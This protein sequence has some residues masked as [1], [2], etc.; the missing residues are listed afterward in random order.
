MKKNYLFSALAASLMLFASCSQEEII[1]TA[2]EPTGGE[3]VTISAALPQDAATRA[4][5][6]VEN[7]KARCILQ[8]VNASGTAIEGERY[9]KEVTGDN[10]TFEF[11]APDQTYQ[12]VLWADYIQ[13]VAET[14]EKDYFYTTSAL[15]S[16]TLGNL[17]KNVMFGTEAA[18]AFCGVIENPAD[19]VNITL[20]RPLA[21][22]NIGSNTPANYEKYTHVS[23]GK[24]NVPNNYNILT[25]Q[26]NVNTTQEIRLDK[27]AMIDAEAGQW[28]YFFVF[29]PVD[30][31]EYTLSIPVTIN[32]EAGS[33]E[34]KSATV[35]VI[36][37]DDNKE[38]NINFTPEGGSGEEPEPE[39]SDDMTINVGFDNE[40]EKPA[41]E[42]GAYVNAAGKLVEDAAEAVAI[43]FDMATD[44]DIANYNG[45]F[46]GKTIK[47]WAVAL[48]DATQQKW[49]DGVDA[50][51]VIDGVENPGSTTAAEACIKG[52]ANT[53]AIQ[54]NGTTA[55]PGA[56]F[57]ALEACVDWAT[58]ISETN[59]SG[60]YMPAIG[61]VKRL[62]DAIASAEGTNALSTLEFT[63]VILSSSLYTNSNGTFSTGIQFTTTVENAGVIRNQNIN[64]SYGA[65]PIVTIFE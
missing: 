62:Y 12:C 61:Q 55:N 36:P 38:S 47:A 54:A 46:P 18:D 37:V 24:M 53:Q 34:D 41:I 4:M 49:I 5:A 10:V 19:G 27:T 39:P 3:L 30:R 50:I 17:N 43:V 9:V 23:V 29:A 1:S 16:V 48:G 26:T 52:Y 65:R 11:T 40:Y 42:V 28:T 33:L 56:T 45:D 63:G 64:N 51:T 35:S 6:T 31:T 60:W 7:Y 32:N 25:K 59:T 58:T 15:P 21:K 2:G 22:V 8:L 14:L 20:K 44:D 57:P 13:S